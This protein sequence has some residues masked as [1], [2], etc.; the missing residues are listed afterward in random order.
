[1]RT[2]TEINEEIETKCNLIG[3]SCQIICAGFV[4]LITI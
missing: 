2:I 1:M 3:R 4:L